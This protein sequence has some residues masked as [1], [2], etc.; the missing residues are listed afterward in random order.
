MLQ[1]GLTEGTEITLHRA[2]PLGDLLEFRVRGFRL[3]LR[4]NEAACLQ[5]VPR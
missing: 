1:M 5:L 2:A 4:K 3:V